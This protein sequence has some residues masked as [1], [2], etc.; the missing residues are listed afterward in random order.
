MELNEKIQQLRKKNSMTQEQLAEKLYV[1]RTAVSKWESGKGYPSIESLKCISKVFGVSID[2]LLSNDELLSLAEAEKKADIEKLC[3][4][5][6]GIMDLMIVSFIFLPLYSRQEIDM[7]H[8]VPLP[9]SD[10]SGRMRV[11]YYTIL[12]GIPLW[13]IVT[14]INRRTE[15]AG[16][17]R[18]CIGVSIALHALTVLLFA[19][20]NQPYVTVFIFLFFIFKII[21]IFSRKSR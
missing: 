16:K 21:L 7:I 13:G 5:V 8:S 10:I 4:L 6:Y 17:Q 20:S 18:A 3:S 15:D 19:V 9:F 2:E 12:L 1:S 11:A 14:L